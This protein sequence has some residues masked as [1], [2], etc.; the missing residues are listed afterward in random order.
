MAKGAL[1]AILSRVGTYESA[2]PD[3][4]SPLWHLGSWWMSFALPCTCNVES[5]AAN[6]A[7]Y[8]L[9]HYPTYLTILMCQPFS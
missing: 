5:D 6:Y 8:D 1:E 7:G 2:L 9:F 4:C 3:G